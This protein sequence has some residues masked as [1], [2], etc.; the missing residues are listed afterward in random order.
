[1]THFAPSRSDPGERTPY[2]PPSSDTLQVV[3]RGVWLIALKELADAD[4]A[5]EVAQETISRLLDALARNGSSIMD[6]GAFARGIAR[7]VISDM[8][9]SRK[10]EDPIDTIANSGAHALADDPLLHAV[11]AE[12][13]A[14]V[15]RALHSLPRGDRDLLR[16]L[17]LEDLGPAELAARTGEPPERVR[18]RKSRALERLRRAFFGHDS[19]PSPT[20]DRETP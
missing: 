10:R 16:A 20:A 18:K 7:H 9:A 14:R 17:Y 2:T 1:M 13:R 3:R 4:Q 19:P 8:R 15:A 5:D 6:P 12:Q 11:N